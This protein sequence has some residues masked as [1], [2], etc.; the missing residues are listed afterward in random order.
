MTT[1]LVITAP[2]TEKDAINA[3]LIERGYGPCMSIP[4]V[5]DRNAESDEDGNLLETPTHCGCHWWVADNED[6]LNAISEL[7]ET[8]F[9]N[10]NIIVR[11][12]QWSRGEESNIVGPTPPAGLDVLPGDVGDVQGTWGAMLGDSIVITHKEF[13]P[14]QWGWRAELNVQS[15]DFD[16]GV[17]AVAIYSDDAHTQYLYT[18]GAFTWDEAAQKWVT[19][20]NCGN[21]SKQTYHWAILY[22]SLQEQKGTLAADATADALFLKYGLP[23]I[24]EPGGGIPEWAAGTAY[25]AGDQ[26]T[27]E[28]TTYTCLQSH[29]AI[30]GWE[31]PNVPALWSPA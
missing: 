21:A 15:G 24:E 17:R 16:P 5:G 23:Q 14:G 19:E 3:E 6:T 1:A 20:W 18:T 28:G 11:G 13:S 9:A 30:V 10:A 29:T 26:V 25:T 12:P 2:W 22:A 7:R 27:Y 8:L 4:M 31:P